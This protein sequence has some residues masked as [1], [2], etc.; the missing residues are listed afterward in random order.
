MTRELGQFFD[1]GDCQL[2]GRVRGQA[3]WQSTAEQTWQV[4]GD[5]NAEGLQVVGLSADPWFDDQLRLVFNGSGRFEDWQ[6]VA[7]DTATL[8]CHA[9]TDELWAQ[10]AAPVAAP[11]SEAE[12][13][14]SLRLVGDLSRWRSRMAWALPQALA[15]DRRPDRPAGQG[16][17]AARDHRL[18]SDP[19]FHGTI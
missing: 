19:G 12:C 17:G 18:R 2:A 11:W 7:L 15:A 9:G 13:P 6:L 10:L 4:S 1:L 14:L 16:T 8:Q 5:M 3:S